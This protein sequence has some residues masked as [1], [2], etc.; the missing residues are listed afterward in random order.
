MDSHEP[1]EHEHAKH[2]HDAAKRLHDAAVEAEQATGR[3][4]ETIEE[5]EHSLALRV[6][7]AVGGFVLIGVGIALLLLPGPG[8]IMIIIGL[9]LLPFSWA[10]RTIALIRRRI[11]GIPDDGAVPIHTWVI[12]GLIVVVTTAI[13]VLLGKQIGNWA[14]DAWSDLWG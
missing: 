8:W 3:H 11:P 12:M 1:H 6:A 10:E 9:S 2:L 5:A 13:F 14:A 7:R 4:E